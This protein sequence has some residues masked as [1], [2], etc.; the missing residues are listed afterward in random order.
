MKNRYWIYL[1]FIMANPLV[2]SAQDRYDVVMT[3]F[4]A[5]PNP[6]VGLPSASFIELKN[7][8]KNNYNLR[9]WKISSGSSAITIKTDFILNADSFL[10]VC[11]SGS[12]SDFMHY[13]AAIGLTG[14]PSLNNDSGTIMLRSDQGNLI[15]ALHYEKSWYRNI[16]KSAG[17]WS[18]EMIDPTKP[19][20][21][22]TNWTASQDPRG[23]TPGKVNSVNGL[24]TDI[25]PPRLIQSFATDSLNIILFFDYPLDSLSASSNAGYSILPE[26]EMPAMAISEQPFFDRVS[27]RLQQPLL[28][29]KIYDVSVRNITGCT[30][31]EI[32]SDNFCK[33]ALPEKAKAGDIIFNEILFNPP[34]LGSDYLE[35]YNRSTKTIDCSELYLAGKDPGG[36]IKLPLPIEKL[37]RSFFPGDYLLLT[38]NSDWV[39]ES[40]L[41]TDSSNIL[42]MKALP[43]LPDDKGGVLLLNGIGETVDDLEYDHHWHSPL[44]TSESGVS[45]ERIKTDMATNQSSNWCSAAAT[46]GY[47][48]PG[49]K[50]SESSADSSPDRLISVEPKIFSPDFDGYQDFCFINYHLPAS[51]YY[52]SISIY[53]VG[54]H[55]VRKLVD[56]LSWSVTGNFRWDGLDDQQK[57]LPTG[58]YIIYTELFSTDGTVRKSKAV[59]VLARR[60]SDNFMAS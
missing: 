28:H 17:G 20:L 45:L 59:C 60:R 55:M 42:Q 26:I 54:G 14:Y 24:L 47:G 7:T 22:E 4:I 46:A 1:L 56:N 11:P 13:G 5:D 52:G 44:L 3:E 39:R 27:L 38:E 2:I 29:G 32:E 58:Q 9:N 37:N 19:C 50:N 49:Y 6:A 33:L 40:Y 48:T 15:H 16:L 35:L 41:K 18:L 43:S 23:G 8:S 31:V 57:P 30:G 34:P 25:M 51:G 12:L 36:N 10:I 53:D 21:G